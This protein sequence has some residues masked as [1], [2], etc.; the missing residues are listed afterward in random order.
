MARLAQHYGR[1]MVPLNP[2]ATVFKVGGNLMFDPVAVRDPIASDEWLIGDEKAPRC[3]GEDC[4]A[5]EGYF[6][7]GHR[8]LVVTGKHPDAGPR[9]YAFF[10]SVDR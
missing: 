4:M 5:Q 2:E 3:R 8:H 1:G 9:R 10:D 7:M 6:Y